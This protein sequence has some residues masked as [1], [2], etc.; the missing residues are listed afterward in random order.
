M[1][2][3]STTLPVTRISSFSTP[4]SFSLRSAAFALASADNRDVT[5]EC[6]LTLVDGVWD[7]GVIRGLGAVPAAGSA[8][9][10]SW[11]ACDPTQVN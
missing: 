11:Q 10:T 2:T 1:F 7:G 6:Q 5:W 3:L 4:E 8:G 9:S